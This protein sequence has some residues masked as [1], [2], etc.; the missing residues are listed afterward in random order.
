MSVA[1]FSATKLCVTGVGFAHGFGE[2]TV[3][4][5]ENLE[6][7]LRDAPPVDVSSLVELLPGVSLRRVPR[8]ARLALLACLR[9]GAGGDNLPDPARQGIVV[10]A[11]HVGMSTSCD[12]MDSILDCGPHLSSP[13][14]FS[15]AV[16]NMG[17]GLLSLFLGVRGPCSTVM[18]GAL[19]FAAALETAG[20]LLY[21]ERADVVWVCVVEE[22]DQRLKDTA[23]ELPVG[24]EGAVCLAVRRW[25]R[26]GRYITL[27]QWSRPAQPDDVPPLTLRPALA[28]AVALHKDVSSP[29]LCTLRTTHAAQH[30]TVTVGIA[31]EHAAA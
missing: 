20:L 26:T 4:A 13:T 17:T 12:F 21:G 18:S 10:G 29:V 14:A 27:P 23:P 9:A 24:A 6:P 30:C 3:L 11:T 7:L 5:A 8:F 1:P 19:S 25:Q 2:A 16:N 22:G 28:A 31:H 15:Y